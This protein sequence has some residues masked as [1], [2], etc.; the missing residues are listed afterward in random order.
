MRALTTAILRAGLMCNAQEVRPEF[1]F[2]DYDQGGPECR[3][4]SP[5]GEREIQRE[6]EN[7]FRAE[8]RGG[9]F[10]SGVGGG[11]NH[12]SVI[13]KLGPEGGHQLADG[14]NFADRNCMDPDGRL[15]GLAKSLR[16]QRRAVVANPRRYL[17]WR[18]I[19]YSQ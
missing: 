17:P 13:R 8:A 1:G 19:W 18:S 3:D 14:E 10:L 4:P 2:G 7:V 15:R 5:R 6:V 16:A 12:D 11:G 9:E